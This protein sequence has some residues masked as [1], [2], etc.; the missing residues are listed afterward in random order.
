MSQPCVPS[1]GRRLL[2]IRKRGWRGEIAMTIVAAASSAYNGRALIKPESEALPQLLFLS[3]L[4]THDCAGYLRTAGTQQS[5]EAT[6]SFRTHCVRSP[7]RWVLYRVRLQFEEL[8]WIGC[9]RSTVIIWFLF[10]DFPLLHW[11]AKNNELILNIYNWYNK[12]KII[13]FLF[14]Y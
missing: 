1:R 6:M 4:R 12:K 8:S 5:R 13:L 2:N 10:G 9:E 11:L 3:S 7:P 14:N